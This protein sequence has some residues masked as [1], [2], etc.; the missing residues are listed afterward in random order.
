MPRI[1]LWAMSRFK[2]SVDDFTWSN[3]DVARSRRSSP[4]GPE[5]QPALLLVIQPGFRTVSFSNDSGASTTLISSHHP[6]REAAII[7]TG[8]TPGFP[9]RVPTVGSHPRDRARPSGLAAPV[10]MPGQEAISPPLAAL[11][12]RS[13]HQP[14]RILL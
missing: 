4:Y 10:T 11:W 9:A 12:L 6:L 13:F 2:A 5:T 1:I 8:R 7:E 3:R 14:R